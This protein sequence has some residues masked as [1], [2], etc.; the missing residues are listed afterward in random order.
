MSNRMFHLFLLVTV[1]FFVLEIVFGDDVVRVG[2]ESMRVAVYVVLAVITFVAAYRS[3]WSGA[4]NGA[5]QMAMSIFILSVAL[6]THALWVPISKYVDLPHWL[7][8]PAII[9]A[10]IVGIAL[11]GL[12][13]IV[14]ISRYR[15]QGLADIAS[16]TSVFCAGLLAGAILSFV[17]VVGIRL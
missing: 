7:Q 10:L 9:T 2:A 15:T 13:Y 1:V 3:F 17:L 14:P 6:A 11:A 8:S 5:E 4:R 12:G 16:W